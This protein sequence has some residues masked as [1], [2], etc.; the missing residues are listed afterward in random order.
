MRRGYQLRSSGFA[1]LG[2]FQGLLFLGRV[3]ALITAQGVENTV[4]VL[5]DF[6]RPAG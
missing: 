6:P 3:V 4:T 1:G 2:V 5:A